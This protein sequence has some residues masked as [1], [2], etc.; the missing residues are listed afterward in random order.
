MRR[1]VL[2]LALLPT[3]A[4]ADPRTDCPTPAPCKVLTLTADEEKVLLGQNMIFDT[5]VAGRQLDLFGAAAYMRQ[6]IAT[7]PAGDMP[8]APEPA[9]KQ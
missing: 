1:L 7:A 3:A 8:K 6:K 9:Q 4:Y 2:L 5:A